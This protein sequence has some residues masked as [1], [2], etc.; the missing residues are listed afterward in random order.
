[1]LRELRHALEGS[2]RV[3][4]AELR[5]LGEPEVILY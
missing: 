4:P 2:W 1:V 5:E 3:V